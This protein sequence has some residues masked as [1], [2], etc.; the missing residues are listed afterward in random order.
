MPHPVVKRR[1]RR[2]EMLEST[3]R[4]VPISFAMIGAQ[5]AATST[6]YRMLVKHPEVV[7]GPEKEMRFF[8]RHLLARRGRW[9]AGCAAASR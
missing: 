6:L 7:G 8:M 3:E 4:H 2:L 5:K 1:N 9:R